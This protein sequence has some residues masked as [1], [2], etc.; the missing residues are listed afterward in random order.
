M[1]INIKPFKVINNINGKM[2]ISG[3]KTSQQINLI[4]SN[5][6]Y[7]D[8]ISEGI[9]VTGMPDNINKTGLQGFS[10]KGKSIQIIK[11]RFTTNNNSIYIPDRL[12]ITYISGTTG[13]NNSILYAWSNKE[14]INYTQLSWNVLFAHSN[15]QTHGDYWDLD[16]PDS[17]HYPNL[18]L[19]II[20][21]LNSWSENKINI[22]DNLFK[23]NN[24]IYKKI[25]NNNFLYSFIDNNIAHSINLQGT[26]TKDN[27]NTRMIVA[28]EDW[29]GNKYD[30]DYNDIILSISSVFFDENNLNDNTFQ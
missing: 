4:K 24:N 29:P 1:S 22:S 18:Y 7:L 28:F 15:A 9:K 8:N 13:G 11:N 20:L 17:T 12:R 3:K 23:F 2:I 10:H 6:Q 26:N 14:N 21:L 19:N 5:K 16:L 27:I 25:Y 30:L